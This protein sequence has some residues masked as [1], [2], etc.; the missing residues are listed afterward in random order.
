MSRL[1]GL[2]LARLIPPLPVRAARE[3]R[4]D[5]AWLGGE[6][7]PLTVVR[8]GIAV[9]TDP[10]VLDL[11]DSPAEPGLELDAKDYMKEVDFL[12]RRIESSEA[13]KR[14]VEFLGHARPLP[15]PDGTYGGPEDRHEDIST[16]VLYRHHGSR[17]SGPVPERR[18]LAGINV[19]IAQATDGNPAQWSLNHRLGGPLY[20]GLGAYSVVSFHPRVLM[21]SDDVATAP[22]MILA[23]ELIHA[24][25]ALAGTMDDAGH[26]NDERAKV[27]QAALAET[28]RLFRERYGIGY[29]VS[30][31]NPGPV[32]ARDTGKSETLQER[33]A[34]YRATGSELSLR[35]LYPLP[36]AETDQGLVV[37]RGVNWEEIRTH[38][39]DVALEWID[40]V[41]ERR[42][43]R[44]ISSSRAE[45]RAER[46]AFDHHARAVVRAGRRDADSRAA[47]RDAAATWQQRKRV[48]GVTEVAIA[49]D[50]GLRHRIAYVALTRVERVLH[51]AV[52]RKRVPHRLFAGASSFVYKGDTSFLKAL[53]TFLSTVDQAAAAGVRDHRGKIGAPLLDRGYLVEQRACHRSPGKPAETSRP[54]RLSP[55]SLPEEQRKQAG[56]IVNR[57][58]AGTSATGKASSGPI[59]DIN[60]GQAVGRPEPR[61]GEVGFVAM[62]PA[63][64]D[65]H[66]KLLELARRYRDEATRTRQGCALVIGL[67]EGYPYAESA[68]D[69]EKRVSRQKRIIKEFA[70]AWQREKPGFPV[71]VLSFLWR[72]P[73]NSKNLGD[74]KTIPYG[75]IR[76]AIAGSDRA[77][78][79]AEALYADGDGS[80]P[81]YF[82]TGDADVKSLRAPDEKELFD[83]VADRLREMDW[84][85][86]FSGGYRLLAND[87]PRVNIAAAMD[88]DVRVAMAGID[89]RTVYLPEPNTFIKLL[90][91][92]TGLEDG[93]SFGTGDQ[94][95]EALAKSL[96]KAR[97]ED[98]RVFD[99]DCSVV[100]DGDRLVKAILKLDTPKTDP[101]SKRLAALRQTYTQ[102][103]A[104]REEWDK[105]V[106]NPGPGSYHVPRDKAKDLLDLLFRI[107]DDTRL[108]ELA[109]DAKAFDEYFAEGR[110]KELVKE[111]N[112]KGLI[113]LLGAYPPLAKI[114]N[115]THEALLRNYVDA[116]R[117][118]PH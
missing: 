35:Y 39:S 22:E 30:K 75:A 59:T 7:L 118:L 108:A 74:Q 28:E 58:R 93:V 57:N 101:V 85:D 72:A 38:G 16:R 46:V 24:A 3:S 45:V 19:I 9:C 2:D 116:Y 84:P 117:R 65:D 102:S 15:D 12:L 43:G 77:R 106:L 100:T 32:E 79:F 98:K 4:I 66:K 47:L 73:S 90:D 63:K 109:G 49:R 110:K 67:N 88:R 40:G 103:H 115:G 37:L 23:H 95:G 44:R 36:V 29:E 80:K 86:L 13:G 112:E 104:R 48:R 62:V 18:D 17:K 91:G 92:L 53:E 60:P 51:L 52:P 27:R 114:I 55:D 107:P 99:P 20:N 31:R 64:V 81:I 83:K 69:R 34:F 94:E 8:P 56:V 11:D 78:E 14:L 96:G 105:R 61:K 26:D 89:P 71:A 113:K 1:K 54:R 68:A 21:L 5:I 50:L 82:H 111:L 10:D 70:D 41:V 25:H 6:P 97:G 87:D 76:Q 33:E 42:K